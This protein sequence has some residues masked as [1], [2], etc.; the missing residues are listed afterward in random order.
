MSETGILVILSTFPD[1]EIA[2]KTVRTLVE[3]KLVACGNIIPGVESIYWWEGKIEETAEVLVIFK[4]TISCGSAVQA[5]LKE[6]HPY[7][8]P[9]IVHLAA[10]DGWPAYFEWVRKSVGR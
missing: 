5:R 7:E 2:R 4:T 10:Q 1:I 8:V 6:L 3:E 9:E